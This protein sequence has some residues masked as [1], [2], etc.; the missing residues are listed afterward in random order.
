MNE[1]DRYC[2]D[3]NTPMQYLGYENGGWHCP[4][5]ALRAEVA[6]LRALLARCEW[7]QDVDSGEEY[8]PLCDRLREFG[9]APDCPF[10]EVQP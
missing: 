2:E 9:H 7:V 8:C 3:C 5:C 6:R 1:D 10:N 4:V